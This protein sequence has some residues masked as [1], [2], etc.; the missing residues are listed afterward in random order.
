MSKRKLKGD[1]GLNFNDLNA[2]I[3]RCGLSLPEL[4]KRIGISKKTIYSRMK[5]ETEF[6]Q[7]EISKIAEVLQLGGERILSIFFAEKV[8]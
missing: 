3:A 2:E 1:E 5:G 6:T 7:S 4:A 8:A